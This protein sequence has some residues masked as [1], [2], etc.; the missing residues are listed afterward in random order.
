M[1]RSF[2]ILVPGFFCMLAA[3]TSTYAQGPLAPPGAPAPTMKTLQQV[4]PRTPIDSLPFNITMPG[5]YYLTGN[6]ITSGTGIRILADSVT[7]DLNGFT[8]IGGTN[9][10]IHVPGPYRDLV[11]RNGHVVGW[12]G[13]GIDATSARNVVVEQV[14]VRDAGNVGIWVGPNAR[15]ENCVAESNGDVGIYVGIGGSVIQCT[16]ISNA[17]IG[18]VLLGDN[19]IKDSLALTNGTQGI[20]ATGRVSIIACRSHAN[21]QHGLVAFAASVVQDSSFVGNALGGIIVSGSDGSLIENCRVADNGSTGIELQ[22]SR[23][24]LSGNVISGNGWTGIQAH[25]DTLVERSTIVSNNS[26][27]S[28]QHRATVIGNTVRSNT[29]NGIVVNSGSVVMENNATHNGANG[30]V[31]N[32]HGSRIEVNHAAFN[33]YLG[34]TIN[35]GNNLVVR[36]SAHANFINYDIVAGNE[37]GP[38]GDMTTVGMHPAANMSW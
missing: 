12:S 32:G 24:R 30:F 23:N 34:F 35:D 2:K 20:Y 27:I 5:S 10:A 19:L 22:G 7:I 9:A 33:G 15:V 28:L 16:A 29:V 25:H 21:G 31:V 4:E 14:H 26:G 8:L 36:N 17:T 1:I 11:I 37:A 3:M 6:L 18:F 13:R 38:I